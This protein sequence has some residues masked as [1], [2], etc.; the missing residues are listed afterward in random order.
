MKFEGSSAL[1]YES[2]EQEVKGDPEL[3]MNGL[4]NR[5]LN[6]K[7]IELGLCKAAPNFRPVDLRSI[8][9]TTVNADDVLDKHIDG[10]SMLLVFLVDHERFLVKPMLDRNF[11]N[12]GNIIVLE[13]ID[14]VHDFAL[15]CTYSRK[16]QEVLQILV[17]AERRRFK[18]D[19]LEQLNELDRQIG[20]N[21][22]LDGDR[23][24]IWISALWKC[25]RDDL[26]IC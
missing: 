20:G 7:S 18:N 15:V 25:G 26:F 14:V 9:L 6:T 13:L 8:V 17:I 2:K 4:T 3:T 12:L 24:I 5:I 11:R 22:S 16:H 23:D 21:E 1:I 19:L 10:I